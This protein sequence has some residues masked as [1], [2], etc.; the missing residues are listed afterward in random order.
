MQIHEP[1]LTRDEGATLEADFGACY[2]ELAGAG[3]PINL[4]V[5]YDDVSGD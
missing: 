3:V 5:Y 2:A 4:V 1:I